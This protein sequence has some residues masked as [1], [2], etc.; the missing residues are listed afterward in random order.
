MLTE[1]QIL[2]T[3]IF[4]ISTE[5]TTIQEMVE[6]PGI[7]Q[8]YLE[9]W[10]PAAISFLVQLVVAVVILLVGRRIIKSIVKIVRKSLERG[11]A[12]AGTISFLCSVTK[13]VLYFFLVMI[14]LSAFGVTTGSVVALLGSAG[15]T[16]GLALQGSLSNFAGGV[17][18]L[19]LKPF[20]VGDYIIDHS[21][22]Q[23]GTVASIT[24][25]Y[26][27]L[28]T[29]DN[30]EILVPNGVLS[31]STITNVS[32]NATRRVDLMIGVSYEAD[33]SK[34]KEVLRGVVERQETVLKEEPV[35][36]FVSELADSSVILGVRAWVKNE[37]YWPTKWQMTEDIKNELD[38]NHIPIPYPQLDIH[39]HEAS[40]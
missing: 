18:I 20:V 24:I 3:S 34:V 35:D 36:I 2:L 1:Y 11:N 5:E 37:D 10:T 29:I 9:K 26:T 17:L 22:G 16:A 39:Y 6:N 7:I 21:G 31:N 27:K 32:S 23:E 13:Y 25:F 28:H 14:I 40:K 38:A 19:V 30:K 33:L 12:E 8:E 15:L 4:E